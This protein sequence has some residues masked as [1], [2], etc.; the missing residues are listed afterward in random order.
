MLQQYPNISPPIF[1][2]KM[3]P[4]GCKKIWLKSGSWDDPHS[5]EGVVLPLSL[6]RVEENIGGHKKKEVLENCGS[7]QKA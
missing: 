4:T 6:R 2:R 1:I 5:I 7:K 3:C